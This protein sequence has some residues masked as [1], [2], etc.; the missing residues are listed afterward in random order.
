MLTLH[1]HAEHPEPR[2]IAHAIEVI[3]RGGVAFY[4]TDTVQA[5]GCAIED[6]KSI[7]RIQR[8]KQMSDRHPLALMCADIRMASHYAVISDFAYRQLRRLLPGPYVFILRASR[9]VPRSLL[10]RP[11]A[12]FA[13]P[14]TARVRGYERTIGVRV[15]AHPISVAL[16]RALDRPLLTT[17]ATPPGAE[18]PCL[19]AEDAKAAWPRGLDVVIDGGLTPGRASTVVSL[20]DDQIEILREGLGSDALA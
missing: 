12:G 11:A 18:T 17:S 14:G 7:E 16:V 4:P 13:A 10:E 20:I 8:L 3:D 1:V 2:K 6:K 5:L 19:D 15:P 9:E